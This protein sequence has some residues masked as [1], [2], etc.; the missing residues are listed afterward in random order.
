MLSVLGNMSTETLNYVKLVGI[1]HLIPC[2][3]ITELFP[4]RCF[5]FP[6]LVNTGQRVWLSSTSVQ[7]AATGLFVLNNIHA[8]FVL[9]SYLIQ[10]K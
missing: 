4:E 5:L 3:I 1:L 2:T 6:L 8:T 10:S 9:F 7:L